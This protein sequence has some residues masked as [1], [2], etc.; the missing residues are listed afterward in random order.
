LSRSAIGGVRRSD[1]VGRIPVPD[2]E[3]H[4]LTE[5]VAADGAVVAPG[6]TNYDMP[7]EHPIVGYA[8]GIAK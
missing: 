8:H 4:H 5:R 2:I 7:S 6:P 1:D 3:T